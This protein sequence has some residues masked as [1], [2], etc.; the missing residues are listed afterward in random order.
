MKER[1]TDIHQHLV[2]GM[3]DGAQSR[4]DMFAML[5]RAAE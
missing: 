3:D 5:R 2:Y 1:V 4:E